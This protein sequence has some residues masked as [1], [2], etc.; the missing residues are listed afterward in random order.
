[1]V[2]PKNAPTKPHCVTGET[3]PAVMGHEFSG[4]VVELDSEVPTG[5]GLKVGHEVHG[6]SGDH[7]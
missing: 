5:L 2:G 4:R 7:G 1:M 6:F 3:I